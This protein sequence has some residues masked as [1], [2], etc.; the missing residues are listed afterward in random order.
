M[1][2][3]SSR[4][5]PLLLLKEEELGLLRAQQTGALYLAS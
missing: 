2:C 4:L 5:R 3:S 1:Q